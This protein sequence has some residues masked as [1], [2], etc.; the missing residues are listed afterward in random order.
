MKRAVY[1]GS[2]DPVTNGHLW[3]IR[4]ASQLFDEVIVSIGINPD[5]KYAFTVEERIEMLSKSIPHNNVRVD[6]FENDFLVRYAEKINAQYIIRGIRSQIDFEYEKQMRNVNS[7]I[8]PSVGTVFLIPPRDLAD[9]SSSFVKGLVGPEGWEV[10]L[11][12][13]VPLGVFEK[14][15]KKHSKIPFDFSQTYWTAEEIERDTTLLKIIGDGLAGNAYHNINHIKHCLKE[16]EEVKGKLKDP[17]A[18]RLALI[19]HDAVYDPKLVYNEE[20]SGDKFMHDFPNYPQSKKVCKLILATKDHIFKQEYEP[21]WDFGYLMDIDLAILGAEPE[22]YYVYRCNIRLEYSH[23]TDA[24]FKKGRREFVQKMLD[25]PQIYWSDYFNNKYEDKARKNL[26]AELE[27][28]NEK[29]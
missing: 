1:A 29:N 17:E 2:F 12:K 10:I 28:L 20:K 15:V 9:V 13:Y 8:S 26:Y 22:K 24:E 6:T 14:F 7:E 23:V 4:Q 5:K 11:R 27:E 16:F 25:R 18:V 19:Y 3:V 21:D